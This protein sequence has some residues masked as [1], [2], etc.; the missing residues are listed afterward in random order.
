MEKQAPQK[1]KENPKD[2]AIKKTKQLL[3]RRQLMINLR[4]VSYTHLT[5]PTKA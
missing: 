4:T 1:T 3:D 5:L 2:Q